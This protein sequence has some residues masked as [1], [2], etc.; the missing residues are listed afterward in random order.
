MHDTCYAAPCADRA[1]CDEQFLNDMN[2]ACECATHP[3]LCR[4]RAKRWY[5]QVQLCGRSS[6]RQAQRQSGSGKKGAVPVEG[7]IPATH[8]VP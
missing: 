7:G 1:A 3:M 8:D 2:C 6:F 5:W 4:L